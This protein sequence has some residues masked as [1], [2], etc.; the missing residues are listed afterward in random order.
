MIKKTALKSLIAILILH[1]L[2]CYAGASEKNL[3]DAVK[4][5][6]LADVKRILNT[7]VDINTYD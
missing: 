5:G 2:G 1:S 7:G 6:N 3:F 4:K